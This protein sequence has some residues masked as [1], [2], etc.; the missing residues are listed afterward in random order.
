MT[1]APAFAPA[2]KRTRFRKVPPMGGTLREFFLYV[3]TIADR[4]SAA[5][6]KNFLRQ[7]LTRTDVWIIMNSQLN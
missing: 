1:G 5:S 6:L 2:Q 3:C 7:G 4:L